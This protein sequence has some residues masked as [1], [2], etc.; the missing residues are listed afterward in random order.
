MF[1]QDSRL[2]PRGWSIQKAA[3]EF[4][5]YLGREALSQ[6]TILH[7][8][9]DIRMYCRYLEKRHGGKPNK[10]PVAV[11]TRESITAFLEEQRT[12]RQN[13]ESTMRRRLACLRKFA[14]FLYEVGV[15]AER[16]EVNISLSNERYRPGPPQELG[17]AE[18]AALLD[19]LRTI[20]PNPRRDYPLFL[21]F[22]RCSCHLGEVL[23]LNVDDLDLATATLRVTNREG[24]ER[25][26]PLPLDVHRALAVYLR[27]RDESATPA[28]FLNRWSQP[29]TKGAIQNVL[30]RLKSVPILRTAGLNVTKLRDTGIMEKVNMGWSPE[31]LA[32]YLGAENPNS[33]NRYYAQAN[34]QKEGPK[35]PFVA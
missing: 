2:R 32:A 18:T 24:R 26:I 12:K 19:A 20:V 13:K 14:L 34:G 4:E 30:R 33:L 29:I 1:H 8:M 7:Y 31:T 35:P 22:L 28:L 11:I 21:L 9:H 17:G 25:I 6:N 27:H 10:I 16:I 15:T 23:R 5:S 3:F